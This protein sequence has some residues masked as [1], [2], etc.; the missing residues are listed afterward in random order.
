VRSDL[1]LHLAAC[2]LQAK[3]KKEKDSNKLKQ[4]ISGVG[5]SW[6]A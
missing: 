1:S 6:E 2:S 4:N 3:S 5:L